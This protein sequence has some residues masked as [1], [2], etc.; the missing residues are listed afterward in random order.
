MEAKPQDILCGE[1]ACARFLKCGF[2]IGP[3]NCSARK[4][5]HTPCI[6]IYYLQHIASVTLIWLRDVLK[7][8]TAPAKNVKHKMNC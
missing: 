3:D 8:A 1:A 6:L 5:R 2:S 4:D 7:H